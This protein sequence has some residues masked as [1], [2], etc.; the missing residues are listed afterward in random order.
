MKTIETK[1]ESETRKAAAKFARTLKGGEIA[2]LYGELGAGKTAWVK[3]MCEGLG[4]RGQITS[5]TFILMQCF[6]IK[7]SGFGKLC[8]V[9]AYRLKNARELMEIGIEEYLG[10]P[11]TVTVIEWAERVEELIRG[12]KVIKIYFEFGK[13]EEER[14]IKIKRPNSPNF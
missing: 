6:R 1:N 8:H 5:P 12:K 11:D 3:G 7:D 2:A 13:K 4:F 10:E 14:R 9:D